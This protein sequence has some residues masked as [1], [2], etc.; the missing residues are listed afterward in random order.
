M[1]G[2]V[3]DRFMDEGDHATSDVH[4]RWTTGQLVHIDSFENRL[5]E[6]E[7]GETG[8]IRE[9]VV[10]FLW[11]FVVDEMG[12]AFR[13]GS[14]CILERWRWCWFEIELVKGVGQTLIIFEK[15]IDLG[16]S[17]MDIQTSRSY[18]NNLQFLHS[19]LISIILQHKYLS[20]SA[21][22]DNTSIYIFHT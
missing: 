19:S 17:Y 12:S 21:C 20:I 13:R 11:V 15:E 16:F 2:L 10:I 6:G 7:G 14:Q 5:L 1:L 8:A 3:V 18:L 9:R 4:S 22:T